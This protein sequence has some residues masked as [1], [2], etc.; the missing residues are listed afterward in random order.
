M[1]PA[2]PISPNH[3]KRKRFEMTAK[4]LTQARLKELLHYNPDTGIFTW[5]ANYSSRTKGEPAG[6]VHHKGY[7]RIG[8][9]MCSYFAHRLAFL[10]MLGDF[11]K[12][13]TDHINHVKDDNRWVNLRDVSQKLNNKNITLPKNNTSGV[14]GVYW[15]KLR[16]KWQ[17]YVIV[18]KKQIHLGLFNCITA[19]TIA[20][21]TAEVKYDFH[22]NHGADK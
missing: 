3:N 8:I 17:A 20:R 19:A 1:E 18:N 15:N 4:I 7:V 2:S 5:R 13:G 10:Y 6:N 22:P 16:H 9:D 11:P 21:K 14:V 12:H